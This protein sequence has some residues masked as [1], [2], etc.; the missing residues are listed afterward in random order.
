MRGLGVRWLVL[1]VAILIT[2][3]MFDGIKVDGFFSAFFGAAALAILN[4]FFRPVLLI[5]TLPINIL[6][7][8]LFT[9]IINA[10]MLKMSQAII[11]G[12]AV[13]GFWTSIFGALLISIASW[14]LNSF[15]SGRGRIQTI[16]LQRGRGNF[17]G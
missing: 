12:F 15:I 7:L 6:S 13:T 16:D 3:Y 5:L 9:L 8:G 10:A 17:W 11:P 1:T 14:A 2:A 4:A